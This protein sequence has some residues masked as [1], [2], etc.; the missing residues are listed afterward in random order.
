MGKLSVD[1]VQVLAARAQIPVHLVLC[2][3]KY[4]SKSYQYILNFE[5][6]SVETLVL[7]LVFAGAIHSDYADVKPSLLKAELSPLPLLYNSH[8]YTPKHNLP[9]RYKKDNDGNE[10][11]KRETFDYENYPRGVQVTAKLE[12]ETSDKTVLPQKDLN[13]IN[14]RPVTAYCHS[15]VTYIP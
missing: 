11:S 13:W 2:Q 3:D 8:T 1:E 15:S 5:Q 10:T 9:S 14:W 4:D 12:D 7:T 6:V